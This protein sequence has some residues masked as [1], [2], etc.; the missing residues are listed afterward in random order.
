ASAAGIYGLNSSDVT[1]KNSTVGTA[2]ED[3]QGLYLY[4]GSSFKVSDSKVTTSGNSS[5]GALLYTNGALDISNSSIVTNG[6]GDAYAV[7]LYDKSRLE[8]ADSEMSALGARAHALVVQA[9]STADVTG[10]KISTGGEK[11]YGVLTLDNSSAKL[12]GTDVATSG[13]LAHAVYASGVGTSIDLTR[14]S[15]TTKGYKS[16]AAY[17]VGGTVNIDSTVIKA[18]DAGFT[19]RADSNGVINVKNIMPDVKAGNGL[20]YTDKSGTL[21]AENS[22]LTGIVAHEAN[23]ANMAMSGEKNGALNIILASSTWTG[24]AD[25][26]SRDSTMAKINITLDA[27]STWRVDGDSYTKGAL[28]NDGLI[29][30]TEG[31]SAFKNV[32]VDSYKGG[33]DSVFFMRTNIDE[34]DSLTVMGDASGSGKIA[35]IPTSPSGAVRSKE[36]V[37]VSG[38]NSANFE[39]AVYDGIKDGKTYVSAGAW[40]YSLENE[41]S[42]SGTKWFLGRG[43]I[44]YVGEAI[45]EAGSVSDTWY[46]ETN[47]LLSRMGIYRDNRWNGGFWAEAAINK[48]NFKPEAGNLLPDNQSFKTGTI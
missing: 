28:N 48:S 21:N 4:K 46:T 30:Y 41:Q 9:S 22:V 7:Y 36:L 8:A 19:F 37:T 38:V 25:L 10:G 44:S 12:Y 20:M 29:D 40:N 6:E 34:A 14:G 3:S 26:L 17:A 45:V 27:A 24:N 47:T 39:L 43:G 11:A 42:A 31:S 13:Q 1:L 23:D 18:E 16:M 32:T 15:I 5:A 33:A 2:G 35:V